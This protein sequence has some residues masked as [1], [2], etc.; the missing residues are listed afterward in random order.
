MPSRT[1]LLIRCAEQEAAIIREQAR[2]ERRTVSNYVLNIVLRAVQFEENLFANSGFHDLRR[3]GDLHAIRAAGPRT[4][5]LVRCST[6]EAQRIRAS[7]KQRGATISGYVLRALTRSWK[8]KKDVA[9]L[10]SRKRMEL[11]L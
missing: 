7:A 10:G 2:I 3:L 4:A 6:E 1:A 5:I 9:A 8:I 11:H